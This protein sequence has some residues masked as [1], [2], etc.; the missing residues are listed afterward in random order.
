M[1]MSEGSLRDLRNIIKWTD[2]NIMRVLGIKQR[3]EQNT[4]PNK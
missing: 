1:K 3:D 4:Y 2:M